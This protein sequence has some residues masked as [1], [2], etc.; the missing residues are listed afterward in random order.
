L[1]TS[2]YHIPPLQISPA[3]ANQI[4]FLSNSIYFPQQINLL[5]SAIQ[6]IFLS[7]FIEIADQIH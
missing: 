7:K 6:F 5:S 4:V 3:I 2:R 1:T